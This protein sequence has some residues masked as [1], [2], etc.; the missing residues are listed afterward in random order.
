MAL[1]RCI[2]ILLSCLLVSNIIS[3]FGSLISHWGLVCP[4]VRVA[5]FPVIKCSY[6]MLTKI[7]EYGIVFLCQ[8]SIL[9]CYL[10]KI[11]PYRLLTYVLSL[12]I[13][14]G[15][16]EKHD[17]LDLK[18]FL[19]MKYGPLPLMLAVFHG[20]WTPVCWLSQTMWQDILLW[21][22]LSA[23]SYLSS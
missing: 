10:T 14:Q 18:V 1:N 13:V 15:H 17:K 21:V 12:W 7:E 22:V 19:M 2:F 5:T 6:Y 9:C 11:F 3:V 20:P 16:S 23:C 4:N 8:M